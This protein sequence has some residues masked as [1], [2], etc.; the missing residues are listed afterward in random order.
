MPELCER[1][2]QA[3]KSETILT[4]FESTQPFRENKRDFK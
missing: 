2:K 4:S 3:I 1:N